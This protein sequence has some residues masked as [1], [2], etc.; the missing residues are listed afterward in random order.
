MTN[1]NFFNKLKSKLAIILAVL[2]LFCLSM[3]VF[4]ACGNDEES[5][6]KPSYSYTETDDS[7]ISNPNFTNG[8]ASK[9]F[10]A[11]PIVS[12]SNWT[13]KYHN[14]AISSY[15][16]SGVVDISNEGWKELSK[17][18]TADKDLLKAFKEFVV[19]GAVVC[20]SPNIEVDAKILS[21]Y[22]LSL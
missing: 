17:K 22:Y 11:Y 18:L 20:E 14:V 10:D 13:K 21:D 16:D 12:P 7:K 8:T 5:A 15:V 1:Q 4:T 9:D 19:K 3:F 2:S 6:K